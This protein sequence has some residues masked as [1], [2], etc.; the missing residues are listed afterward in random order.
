[1]GLKYIDFVINQKDGTSIGGTQ[2]K[3]YDLPS[4]EVHYIP[5]L[6]FISQSL[7]GAHIK[8]NDDVTL[9]KSILERLVPETDGCFKYLCLER[10]KFHNMMIKKMGL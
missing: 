7:Y 1:M 4:G 8:T 2:I 10:E 5:S 9:A 6:N 3:R